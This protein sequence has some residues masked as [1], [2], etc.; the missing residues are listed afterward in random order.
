MRQDF[1]LA[2]FASYSPAV[3]YYDNISLIFTGFLFA[4]LWFEIFKIYQENSQNEIVLE[5]KYKEIQ[6]K[7][8]LQDFMGDDKNIEG[9]DNK[10]EKT[11]YW[12]WKTK[13]CGKI[14][15]IAIVFPTIFWFTSKKNLNVNFI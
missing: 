5:Y 4:F 13:I 11:Y 15:Y 2:N 12:I 8:N 14:C 3:D 9:N 10:K 7:N 1:F 6:Q